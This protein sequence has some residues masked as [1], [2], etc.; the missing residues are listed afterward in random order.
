VD[1]AKNNYAVYIKGY[2]PELLDML[3]NKD[4]DIEKK[5]AGINCSLSLLT[6][7]GDCL[8]H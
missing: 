3:E 6:A 1:Q 5:S 8:H 4:I 2:V 7:F